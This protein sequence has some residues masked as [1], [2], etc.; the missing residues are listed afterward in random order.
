MSP[1][2]IT[3]R[4]FLRFS[5]ATTVGVLAAACAPPGAAPAPEEEGAPAP[6]PKEKVVI[7]WWHGWGGMTGVNAMQAVADAFNEEHEDIQVNR[8]QVSQINEKY[9]TAIAGGT[10]PDVEIGNLQYAQYWARGVVHVLDDW[11]DASEIIDRDDIFSSSWQEASWQGKTYGVPTV[12]SYLRFALC[13]NE[14][15]VK[16]AGLDPD[17]PP[18]DWDEAFEWHKAIT[19]FDEAGNI[20]IL[21][22]DPMDAMGGSGPGPPDP[23]FWP[24][25]YGFKWWLP[26]EMKFNFDNELFVAALATIKRFYDHV[27]VEKMAGYRSSYG[28]WTQSPTASFP[29]GVQAMIIN[30]YWT[31][32]ELVH[33]AP[34]KKFRYTWPPNSPERR[35]IKFQSTGGHFGNIPKGSKHPE[36]A[37]KFIEFTTT[38]KACDIIFSQTGWLGARKSYLEKVDPS[39]APGLEFYLRSA[40]EADE[41]NSSESCP[42]GGFVG[43]NWRNTVDA[44][45]FGDK[46]PEEAARDLQEMCTEELRK[47]FPEL[48]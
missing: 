38:D 40:T 42:I 37:F 6:A 19:T 1:Q 15:L 29:A 5:A 20:E 16:E 4:E 30:G 31:P 8:L 45:N 18:L 25:S 28:T 43:Q 11:I 21:G 10:P 9:M 14:D 24:Q 17:N 44:V 22:F 47:Q 39:K 36:E 48:V 2:K 41:M 27:G 7:E 33:S 23:F 46:T 26:D 13:Y 3:R 32:G 12:E 35:G 34:D